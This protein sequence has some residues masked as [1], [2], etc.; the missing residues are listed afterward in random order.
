MSVTISITIPE[1]LEDYYQKLADNEGISRS[2]KIGNVL[3]ACQKRDLY[4]PKSNDCARSDHQNYCAT[5]KISCY[6]PQV[7]ANTCMEY[8]SPT[9]K[10]GKS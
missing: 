9:A 6:A 2:R 10:G 3:L 8:L 4:P 5:C 1:Q 7:E